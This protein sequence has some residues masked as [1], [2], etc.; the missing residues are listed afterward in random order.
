MFWCV[1]TFAIVGVIFAAAAAAAAAA[2]DANHSRAAVVADVSD[3]SSTYMTTAADGALVND[4]RAC[5]ALYLCFND[6]V[7]RDFHNLV[8]SFSAP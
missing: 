7:K 4:D 1:Q 8:H 6:D 2:A 5:A 3:G